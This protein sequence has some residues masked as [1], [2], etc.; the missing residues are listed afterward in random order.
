MMDRF[1]LLKYALVIILAFVGVKMLLHEVVHVPAHWS[2]IVIALVLGGGIFFSL[3]QNPTSV[4]DIDVTPA[5]PEHAE[6][7]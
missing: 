6:L 1:H 4:A 3:R 2:L 5:T 7:D